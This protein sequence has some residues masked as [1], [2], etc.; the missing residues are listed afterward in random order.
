MLL[1]FRQG[2][3][4][5][6]S[7]YLQ[8]LPTAV[9][10]TATNQPLVLTF[11]HGQS[12]YLVTIE[13]TV[14]NAWS[15]FGSSSLPVGVDY[16]LAVDVNQLTGV[17]SYIITSHEPKHGK[18]RPTLPQ[19][20][21][22]F[23]D[24]N[25]MKMV[26][27]SGT[28]WVEKIRV[29]V[30]K[31]TQSST[32]E[33]IAI[34]TQIGVTAKRHVGKIIYDKFGKPVLKSNRELFTTE[35]DMVING[36]IQSPNS[37]ET[38]V[39]NAAAAEAI[40]TFSV[41][42][43][44]SFGQVR[45]ATYSDTTA[46]VVMFT[47]ESAQRTEVV[48]M[49]H[50]GIIT[51]PAWNWPTVNAPL[52]IGKSGQLVD[53][54][55]VIDDP[56]LFAEPPV[57]RVVDF[58]TIR[59]APAV[60]PKHLNGGTGTGPQGIKGDTG[61]T[62]PQG[63]VGNTGPQ[64][65]TGPTGPQG[66]PGDTGPVGP[67]G[68]TGPIGPQGDTGP[69]GPQ[70]DTGPQG[71]PGDPGG[72]IGPMG[73]IG[74]TGPQG[75]TGPTGPQGDT[76]PAGND[77]YSGPQGP[78]GDTGPAGPQGDTGPAGPQGIQGDT[79]PVGL[80]GPQGATGPQGPQGIQ[81][82][83]G[84]QGEEGPR[85]DA[86]LQGVAGPTGPQGDVGPQGIQGIQ[87]IQGEPGPRGIVGP[88]GPQGDTGPQ[89]ISGIQ[90]IAGPTGP[91]GDT[92]PAGPQGIQ[93]DTGPVGP[94]GDTGPQGI[95]GDTG[96]AGLGIPS[97]GDPSTILVK[98][99]STNYDVRWSTVEDIQAIFGG[100]KQYVFRSV[101]VNNGVGTANVS[102]SA[103]GSQVDLDSVSITAAGA[104]LLISGVPV[105]LKMQTL[106][107]AYPAGYNSTTG[108]SIQY[109]ELFGRITSTDMNIPLLVVYNDGNPSVMQPTTN[110]N[111]SITGGVVQ[112]QKTGLVSGTPY[113]FRLSM[114]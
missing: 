59:F 49:I 72:P 100:V 38:R 20:D 74:P 112:V 6:Q 11:A 9:S 75:D 52:W 26:V 89:G 67:Q 92:G 88:T 25:S 30:G 108:F 86:G 57:A 15:G 93:G 71:I 35:D 10:L 21:Q 85:G 91:Q 37:L 31:F 3:I 53:I 70:G 40:P 44:H 63:L 28:M 27:W 60:L 95:Q 109:P 42:T 114:L 79:G 64:G 62:G 24:L 106:S 97:G 113:R 73:P 76:G 16:W 65:D 14:Q 1:N 17:V 22:H 36:V 96:P 23:F 33:Q 98:N 41:V 102:I 55:P 69:I 4:S 82:I 29:V 66:I 12:D 45:L 87:G 2:V 111:Y 46:Q 5:G 105:E 80:V 39:V 110:T 51:N 48:S 99:S 58:N 77:G 83:Q 56:T 78:Q 34:G 90:G 47:R 104:V 8:V 32:V 43:Y 18:V 84:I 61:P 81:G 13:E 68:D 94:Q 101:V 103:F 7:T 107:V 54:D 19:V 50:Q